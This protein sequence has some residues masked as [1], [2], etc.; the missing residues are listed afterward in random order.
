[1]QR[2]H[3]PSCSHSWFKNYSWVPLDISMFAK[4]LIITGQP[5]EN[6]SRMFIQMQGTLFARRDGTGGVFWKAKEKV[7]GVTQ[8]VQS[9]WPSLVLCWTEWLGWA[10][11]G[12]LPRRALQH[13]H[14]H[15]QLK[16]KQPTLCISSVPLHSTALEWA[17]REVNSLLGPAAHGLEGSSSPE[18][19]HAHVWVTDTKISPSE[20]NPRNTQGA[21]S[22]YCKVSL[23]CCPILKTGLLPGHRLCPGLRDSGRT[24]TWGS[25]EDALQCWVYLRTHSAASTCKINAQWK[26]IIQWEKKPVVPLKWNEDEGQDSAEYLHP[27]FCLS[28][29]CIFITCF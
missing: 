14:C 6:V 13:K 21:P 4:W 28:R 22:N 3:F 20:P 1:M 29:S 18:G 2:M 27:H 11:L 9:W 17:A 15:L 8:C 26:G 19:A 16:T 5:E 23:S 25:W 10:A 7:K 24:K 12:T